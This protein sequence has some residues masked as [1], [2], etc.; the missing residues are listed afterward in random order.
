MIT[1][2]LKNKVDQ[3]WTAFWS[4]GIANPLSVIEQ[5]T[6]LLFTKRLDETAATSTMHKKTASRKKSRLAKRLNQLKAKKV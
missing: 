3:L 1:G 6:Y 5:I 2:E 4:G